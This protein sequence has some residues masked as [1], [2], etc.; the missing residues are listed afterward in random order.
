MKLDWGKYPSV[1]GIANFAALVESRD[2]TRF[3]ADS[4]ASAESISVE[5][6]IAA[7]DA[8]VELWERQTDVARAAGRFRGRTRRQRR[9]L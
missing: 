4:F 7:L 2:R 8:F 6:V 9:C 3:L 5:E 1:F